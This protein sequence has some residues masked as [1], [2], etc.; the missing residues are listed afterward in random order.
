MQIESA[1][2]LIHSL[3]D[4]GLFTAE[5][6]LALVRELAPVGDNPPALMRHLVHRD[7]KSVV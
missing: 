6:L 3:R 2:T 1:D 5:Q 7:R 4:S